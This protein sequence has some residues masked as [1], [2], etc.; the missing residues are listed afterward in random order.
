MTRINVS[1]D[2]S[3]GIVKDMIPTDLPPE[4]W[5][6]GYNVRFAGKAAKMV[7]GTADMVTTPTP[8]NWVMPL[9]TPTQYFWLLGLSNQIQALV[10]GV[11]TDISPA[12]ALNAVTTRWQGGVF[13]GTPFF[14][15]AKN[16]PQIWPSLTLSTKIV[17][18]TNWPAT[19]LT[20]NL[21]TYKNFL[22]A[23]A[24]S[25]SGT[26]YARDVAWSA[27][28]AP[29]T[30]PSTW[31]QADPTHEA[32]QNSLAETNGSLIDQ[33]V[34][35][36]ANIL[37]K[38]DSVYSMTYV[39]GQ[40]IFKFRKLFSQG[41]LT[42]GCVDV[43]TMQGD[44]HCYLSSDNVYVHDGVTNNPILTDY[45]QE[46]LFNSIDQGNLDKCFVSTNSHLNEIWICF[47]EVNKSVC[48]AA[49]VWNYRKNT[50]SFR[51]LPGVLWG[52]SGIVPIGGGISA[53]SWDTDSGTWATDTTSW[54]E[55]NYKPAE[56]HLVLANY[57]GNTLAATG[58]NYDF[59]GTLYKSWLERTGLSIVGQD[60]KGNPIYDTEVRK[61]VN[62]IW[63]RMKGT[64]GAV[65]NIN[66][67]AQETEDGDISW[68][69]N[70]PYPFTI[71]TSQKQSCFA[72][73]RILAVRFEA[74]I[75][76]G[77]EVHGYDLD[78]VK[79]GKY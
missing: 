78:I 1:G 40:Y 55:K 50:F 52:A 28:A 5:S 34:L 25:K 30:V 71:G 38:D 47:P 59:N 27:A 63:P 44:K 17:A 31:D 29:G 12:T 77:W 14:N 61:Q 46:A 21:G 70:G 60:R 13:N 36:D 73:G 19:W 75:N 3:G 11:L 48:T 6:D 74:Q 32:G 35:G 64:R 18:L 49:L 39:G 69:P 41:L 26:I 79:L 4:A 22:V 54:G 23:L 65:V 68:D 45:W 20:P 72:A 8:P 43:F 24:I 58:F 66:V 67:G 76:Q 37:Y 42:P 7:T 53:D 57:T 16:P 9:Q 62:E 51:Q 33:L 15:N 10:G 56:T 2:G